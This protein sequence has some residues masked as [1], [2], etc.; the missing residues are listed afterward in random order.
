MT[1]N[2]NDA[3]PGDFLISDKGMVFLYEKYE[4]DMY[5]P[6]YIRYPRYEYNGTILTGGACGCRTDDGYVMNNHAKRLPTDHNI[7][8]IIPRKDFLSQVNSL[9]VWW[10]QNHE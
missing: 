7:V 8:M 3:Q 2:L 9:N 10:S 1:V 4:E 6:H 5:F